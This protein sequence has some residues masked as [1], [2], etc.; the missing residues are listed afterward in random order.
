MPRPNRLAAQTALNIICNIDVL[1]EMYDQESGQVS[2]K[3]TTSEEEDNHTLESCEDV[4]K[5]GTNWV[6]LRQ[7]NSSGRVIS[8]NVFLANPGVKP[9]AKRH[10]V[11]PLSA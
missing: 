3:C 8:Q 1:E 6:K 9:D 11:S 2:D 10:I 7:W 4:S 5:D